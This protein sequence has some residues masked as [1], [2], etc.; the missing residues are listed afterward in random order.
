MSRVSCYGGVEKSCS[1]DMRWKPEGR[2]RRT[3]RWRLRPR[4][5]GRR[6]RVAPTT[7]RG[8]KWIAGRGLTPRDR[9]PNI[10]LSELLRCDEQCSGPVTD[11]AGLVIPDQGKRQTAVPCRE[12]TC[13]RKRSI[14]CIYEIGRLSYV[15]QKCTPSS[16][17]PLFSG[18][19][20]PH[21]WGNNLFE[22]SAPRNIVR[23]SLA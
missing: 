2:R 15:D 12:G 3:L 10:R 21:G 8:L 13:G 9:L 6:R 18:T 19:L 23:D 20:G 1:R 16:P 22:N 4:Q 14:R 7:T 5:P 11:R 17:D